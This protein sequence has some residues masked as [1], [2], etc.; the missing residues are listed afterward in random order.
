MADAVH[1]ADIIAENVL[2][3]NSK[4][5]GKYLV[6]M[7][8][9]PSGSIEINNV[10]EAVTADA[11][12]KAL[13]AGGENV[14]LICIVHNLDPLQKVHS[15]LPE[16]YD[17]HVGKPISEVP[18]PCGNCANYA[19]HFLKPSLEILN[20]IGIN[21]RICRTDE[22]YRAGR[23]SEAITTALINRN[24]IVRMLEEL[25][26]K[27]A[28]SD[29]SPFNPICDECGMITKTKVT[30]FSPEAKTVDYTC[31]CGHSGTVPVAGGGKLTWSV[32]WPAFWAVLGITIEAFGKDHASKDGSYD[33]GKRIAKEIYGH[34]TFYPVVCEQIMPG[35][36][37]RVNLP[38]KGIVSAVEA[39]AQASDFLAVMPPEFLRYLII[40]TKPQKQIN[41]DPGKTFLALMDEYERLRV[42]LREEDPLLGAF[43]RRICE[44]SRLTGICQSQ[45][46]FKQMATI[47]QVARG[48]F[49]QIFKI[50][51]RS[52]FSSENEKCIKELT[53]R[54]SLWLEL[55]APPFMKFNVKET[56]PVQAAT[57]SK[58]QKAFLSTFA[59]LIKAREKLSGEDNN[60]TVLFSD[61]NPS[62]YEYHKLIYSA[63][64]DGS[65]LN[66]GIAEKINAQVTPPQVD[67]REVALQIDPRDLF[68]A[69]Y[70]SI[71]G[72]S[73]GPRAGW[74]LSSFEKEFLVK[75]FEEASSY[76]PGKR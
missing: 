12:Y 40:R 69:I 43:E 11:I 61:P 3:E 64:E 26:G 29:W 15:F 51:K 10:R 54:A 35:R 49:D 34:K 9:I 1:W 8:I 31:A 5:L 44:L 25:S 76:S 17:E 27:A 6:A 33:I 65:E 28:E 57:L 68:K 70:I 32:E 56:V 62:G 22:M 48:D 67:S 37:R 2:N 38:K 21:P 24:S 50:V 7:G 60:N 42:Q 18:C 55:Y 66:R 58:L 74:F 53:D 63:A 41:F 52:S 14:D 20:R 59:A 45:I 71:L 75:R 4:Y 73:S 13:L 30:G 16:S 46:P 47:Y 19:E 23:C 39:A 36:H 72:Q